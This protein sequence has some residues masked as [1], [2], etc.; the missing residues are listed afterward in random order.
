MNILT[1]LI[2]YYFGI[3]N[4]TQSQNGKYFVTVK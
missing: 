4:P 2:G 3:A 1:E